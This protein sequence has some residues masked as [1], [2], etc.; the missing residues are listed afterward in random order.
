MARPLSS[1]PTS[2]SGMKRALFHRTLVDG[3]GGQTLR[4]GM[5]F[6]QFRIAFP[7]KTLRLTTFTMADGKLEQYQVASAE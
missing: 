2:P 1:D 6:R 5:T 3:E 4:G 7:K